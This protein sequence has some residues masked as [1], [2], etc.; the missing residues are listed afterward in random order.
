[1][2]SRAQVTGSEI[3]QE[4]TIPVAE[5]LKQEVETSRYHLGPIRLTPSLTIQNAGYT[6]DL[7][8]TG[9]N[10]ISDYTATVAAGTRWII[11]VGSKIYFQG[12]ILPQ[13]IWYARHPEDRTFGGT[14]DASANFLFHRFSLL[15][16][17]TS[18]R[19]EGLLN[20]ETARRV[21]LDD[22]TGRAQ[23]EV[24]LVGPL[25]LIG[26]ATWSQF[27]FSLS[28]KGPILGADASFLDR[29]EKEADVGLRWKFSDR[30]TVSGEA[31]RTTARFDDPTQGGDNDSTA[32]LLSVYLNRSRFFLNLS[33]GYRRAEPAGAQSLFP[34]FHTGTGSYFLSY[35]VTSKIEAGLY[36]SRST[37]YSDSLITPYYVETANGVSLNYQVGSRL[38]LR[39]LGE[40]GTNSYPAPVSGEAG[41]ETSRRLDQ[42]VNYGGGFEYRMSPRVSISMQGEEVRY[43]SNVSG[44]SR[45]FFRINA[46][47]SMQ[48]TSGIQIRGASS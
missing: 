47:V 1:M 42:L 46:G 15:V 45:S 3:P 35:F 23:A 14:Y 13:Y 21:L 33:G 8:G 12:A 44:F 36:G 19:T 18:V 27:H 26:G 38:N 5:E 31:E 2:V 30:F 41:G 20:S 37:G 16:D 28:P 22:R 34:A 48:L 25:F 7:F 32:Y 9:E 43:N 29:K 39:A 17:A 11:P 4:R 10:Q 24:K 40:Y 6:S